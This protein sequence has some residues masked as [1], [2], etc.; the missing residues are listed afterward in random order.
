MPTSAFRIVLAI[1]ILGALPA[2]GSDPQPV[3]C[4]A[5][6]AATVKNQAQYSE[7]FKREAGVQ[8]EAD[9]AAAFATA[10]EELTHDDW[11]K[12]LTD[13]QQEFCRTP[14][15]VDSK[16][17]SDL[18]DALFHKLACESH[19]CIMGVPPGDPSDI[20]AVR[21]WQAGAVKYLIL[22][23]RLRQLRLCTSPLPVN[24]AKK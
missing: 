4:D 5:D 8:L 15:K 18:E 10:N 24:A 22:T 14:G 9:F 13:I 12:R 1:A 20:E 19:L 3:D 7:P 23:V 6:C 16:K 2:A 17:L 21:K 11:N